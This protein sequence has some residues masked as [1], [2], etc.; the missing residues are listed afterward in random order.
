MSLEQALQENTEAVLRLNSNIELLVKQLGGLPNLTFAVS[1]EAPAAE[2]PAADAPVPEAT[3]KGKGKKAAAQAAASPATAT[4]EASAA[5]GADSDDA[6]NDEGDTPPA[7]K[8]TVE[9]ARKKAMEVST[10]V[11]KVRVKEILKKHHAESISQLKDFAA[12]VAD[13]DDALQAA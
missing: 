5:S 2:A 12:F 13:C 11:S 9:E 4:E 10:R 7:R 3:T 8:V 6:S 1:A